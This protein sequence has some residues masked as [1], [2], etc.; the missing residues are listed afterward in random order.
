MAEAQPVRHAPSSGDAIRIAGGAPLRG[1]IVIGGS[2]NYALPALCA[3]LL[4]SERCVFENVPAIEDIRTMLQLLRSLGA[5]VTP[6][7]DAD[8]FME[9]LQ[10]R[11][12]VSIQAKEI[13]NTEIPS[14]LSKAM[15][16]SFLAAGPLLGRLNQVTV[17]PAG[18]DDIGARPLDVMI[19]GLQAL[20]VRVDSLPNGT[21]IYQT[22]DLV[23]ATI[24]LAYPA[25]TGTE[26]LMMA[27]VLASGTTHIVNACAE[28]EIVALG[29]LLNKMGA[30]VSGMGSSVITIQGVNEL[31]GTRERVFP[32]RLVAGTYAIAAVITRGELTLKGVRRSDM[33]P[34]TSKLREAGAEVWIDDN[35]TMLV[36][37]TGELRPLRIQ[38]LPFPG[39]PTDQQ[40]VMA[41]LLTQCNGVS[42]LQER[43]YEK[44][45]EYVNDLLAMGADITPERITVASGS[46]GTNERI[47]NQA[48]FHGPCRLQG[49]TLRARDIRA[50]AALL[51]AGLIAEGQTVVTD[52]YHLHRGYEDLVPKLRA[53]GADIV[54]VPAPVA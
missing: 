50:G 41:V 22:D 49:R 51:L 18:G 40:A 2:K 11:G 21:A 38:A 35:E 42:R 31:H 28:P 4:T 54:S 12:T 3:A 7:P 32:D 48:E 20:G 10:H 27:A 53:V 26:N 14:H 46:A 24:F 39:F 9:T 44:R 13:T 16:G 47:G 5:T 15:R 25:H 6:D 19:G 36:R 23:G 1:E 37:S 43:V 29:H 33:L 8:R 30:R 52:A 45:L 17:P 34:V